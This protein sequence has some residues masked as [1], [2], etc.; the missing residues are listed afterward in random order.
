[1]GDMQTDQEDKEKEWED[2]AEWME[3][4]LRHQKQIAVN[5]GGYADRKNIVNR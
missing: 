3:Y 2:S 1:M 4:Q 5:S